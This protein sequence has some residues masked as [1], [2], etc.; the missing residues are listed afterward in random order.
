MYLPPALTNE[1]NREHFKNFDAARIALYAKYNAVFLHAP[2][3]LLHVYTVATIAKKLQDA[4]IVKSN[5][6]C[7]AQEFE[8]ILIEGN[9]RFAVYK[10]PKAITDNI[11]DKIDQDD[12]TQAA[13][14]GLHTAVTRYDYTRDC[15]FTTYAAWW[16]K[17]ELCAIVR[18]NSKIAAHELRDND[19]FD[20][21]L[22]V[23]DT[24]Y[25]KLLCDAILAELYKLRDNIIRLNGARKRD[26]A[27][28]ACV[29]KY[30]DALTISCTTHNTD[31]A[32]QL[33]INRV[34]VDNAEKRLLTHLRRY[35]SSPAKSV[36]K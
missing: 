21:Q 18:T 20:T 30:I 16:I 29:L 33:D 23:Q 6:L 22:N 2:E 27:L 31:L 8:R 28:L 19:T 10:T 17:K 13:F 15:A 14:L 9:L 32:A 24:L 4:A 36:R 34:T 11:A 26:R 5:E 35:L 3:T 7:R 25:N 12:L 1:K